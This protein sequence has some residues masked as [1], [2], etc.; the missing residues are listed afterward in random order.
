MDDS[1]D[2][3]D[4]MQRVLVGDQQ[5]ATVLFERFRERLFRIVRLRMDQRLKGRVDS[6]DIVQ[7]AYLDASQRLESYAPNPPT[8]IFL[9]LRFLTAQKLIDTHR[10]HLGTE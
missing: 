7:E 8:S 2:L 4:L 9:W 5:S 10:Q 1:A 3:K 6:E